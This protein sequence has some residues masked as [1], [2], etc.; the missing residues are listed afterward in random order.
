[1]VPV[2]AA[3]RA[4]ASS[5][6]G[7]ASRWKAVG[8]TRIGC[9]RRT[10]S[11][12]IPGRTRS[13]APAARTQRQPPPGGDVVVKRD[14]VAGAALDVAERP[15]CSWSHPPRARSRRA[16]RQRVRVVGVIGG[17]HRY[18]ES[19][20]NCGGGRGESAKVPGF[21]R[22]LWRAKF[23][24]FPALDVVRGR[25]IRFDA[26]SHQVQLPVRTGCRSGMANGR[27]AAAKASCDNCFFGQNLL[28]A[29]ADVRSLCDVP[30]GAPGRTAPTQSTAVR[31]PPGAATAGGLGVPVAQRAGLAPRLSAAHRPL[32]YVYGHVL[33]ADRRIHRLRV[34][35]RFHGLGDGHVASRRPRRPLTGADPLRD[36]RRVR[37][38]W[39]R[40]G[41]LG[42]VRQ[43]VGAGRVGG[44]VDQ[45]GAE[46]SQRRQVEDRRP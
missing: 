20:G 36:I 8:A 13:L 26:A 3:A 11:S 31:V 1:M 37:C 32:V 22:Y 5:P 2:A 43:P 28:C 14:L 34:A 38:C 33:A 24:R 23:L 40:R 6:S 41:G 35:R 30:P 4:M 15:P 39:R 27:A 10:P 19:Y 18:P 7:C 42:S 44:A 21:C 45:D 9:G 25:G 16:S 46:H 12:S 29:V 17:L